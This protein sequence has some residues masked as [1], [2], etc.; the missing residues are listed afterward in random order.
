MKKNYLVLAIIAATAILASCNQNTPQSSFPKKHLIEEFT[1]QGC[2]YCPYG[3]DCMSEFMANDTNWILVMHHYG[4]LPDKFSVPGSKTITNKLG[5]DGAPSACIDRTPITITGKPSLVVLPYDLPGCNK[6]QFETTTYASVVIENQYNEETD[7]LHVHVSG[8]V[9]REDAPALTLTVLIKESGMVG[10][11]A[12]YLGSFEGWKEFRHVCAVRAFL[13]APTGDTITMDKKGRYDAHYNFY[14][15]EKWDAENCMVVAFLSESF[16]P[17]VQAEQ[18]PVVNGTKGGADIHHGGITAVPV[19]DYYPEPSVTASP[20][21]YSGVEADTMLM[22]YAYS[23][24]M[25]GGKLW[26]IQAVNDKKIIKVSSTNCLAFLNLFLVTEAGTDTIPYGTYPLVL[27]EQPGTAI[28]GF[29][30]DERQ[31][32]DG[33]IFYYTSQSYYKQGYLDPKAQWL[34][35]KGTLTIDSEGWRIEAVSLN[36]NTIKLYSEAAFSYP[37]EAPRKIGERVKE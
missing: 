32:I 6:S 7:G 8:V 18:R 31:Q 2:G 10:T 33:S 3:M 26:Q 19:P 20:S 9:V 17:V 27:T 21:T 5:V 29:R 12:D 35:T 22:A 30:D 4:Y 34:L 11:Q 16:R 13:S 24:E 23:E 1:G 36:G 15:D 28:A 37:K 25:E 14:L